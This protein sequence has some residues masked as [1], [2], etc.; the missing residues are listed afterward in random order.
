MSELQADF[1][2]GV[3]Y[4]DRSGA[5]QPRVLKYPNGGRPLVITYEDG[6]ATE[7]K[8]RRVC[9]LVNRTSLY[10][11]CYIRQRDEE[12]FSLVPFYGYLLLT[13]IAGMALPTC[14]QEM[15]W[16]VDPAHALY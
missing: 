5:S 11:S 9:V 14:A 15:H 3:G 1:A 6:K 10:H 12:C 2:V 4:L 7:S 8:G 13:F 16:S